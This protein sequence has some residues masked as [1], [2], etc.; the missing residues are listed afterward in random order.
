MPGQTGRMTHGPKR[1]AIAVLLALIAMLLVAAGCGGDD[2]GGGGGASGDGAS[3]ANLAEAERLVSELEQRPTEINQKTPIDK[4]IP[5]GRKIAFI[6]CGPASCL[7]FG[8]VLE[9]GAQ[10]LGWS[11]ETITTDG[12]PERLSNA[13]QSAI[14]GNADAIFLP[15]A[16]PDALA[17]PIAQAKKAGIEFVACCSVAKAPSL[18]GSEKGNQVAYNVSTPKQNAP[19]GDA[20][21]AKVVADSK[22]EANALY[23]NISAFQI[24]AEVGKSFQSTYNKLCPGCELETLEIPLT[25]LGKD[26]PDRIVSHLRSH[27]DVNYVVLSEASALYP[28]L[29]GALTAAGLADK[30]KV[31]GRGGDATVYQGVKSG[32]II[33]LVPPEHYSYDYA[34]LDALA[35]KWAGVPVQETE[36]NIWLVTPETIP[37]TDQATFPTVE[38]YKQQWAELWGKSV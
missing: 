20:L 18:S 10:M 33:A 5:T 11:V 22:G 6:S 13:V 14:R 2:D 4:P 28:G 1:S 21:A 36:P 8:K 7:E 16:D 35:R 19:I 30:V 26:A 37:E 17:G 23:V 3:S 15:A 38:N 27:P 24:L 25:A 29:K 32:D 34:I 9:P 31:I 12:S